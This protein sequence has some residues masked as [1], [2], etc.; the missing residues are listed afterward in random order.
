MLKKNRRDDMNIKYYFTAPREF[1]YRIGRNTFFRLMSDEKYLKM[2][3][4]QVTGKVLNLDN[5]ATFNEKIQWLKLHDRKTIYTTMVDKYQ[6][7]EYVADRIGGEYVIPTL[8]VWN[9]F[10]DIDFEALPNQFVLKCTHDSGGIVICRD[11]QKL[12]KREAKRRLNRSLKQ[13]YFW[14]GR[15]WPYKNVKPRILAEQY[16]QDSSSGSLTDYKFYCFNGNPEYLYISTGLENHSTASISFLTPD[17][18]FAPFGRSD[19]KPFRELPEKPSLFEDMKKLAAELSK[20]Q[21]FLR[22]DLYQIEGKI[23]FSEF[24]FSPCGGMMPFVPQEWDGILG[25]MIKF[26]QCPKEKM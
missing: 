14:H 6:A 5:P 19:Y 20:G 12:D 10:D 7:K 25:N 24:T 15:E 13:N 26:P 2:R 21:A 16:M 23:Y 1:I 4:K 9:K 22:V 17:W 18:E 11:K 8:G 3:F